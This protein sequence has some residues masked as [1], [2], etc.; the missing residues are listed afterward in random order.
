MSHLIF[1][2]T[3]CDFCYRAILHLLKLDTKKNLLFA[4]LEGTTAKEILVGPNAHY[5]HANS[6]VL[7]ENYDSDDR[8]FYLRSKAI[9]R[10]YWLLGNRLIGWLSF[11]PG[12]LCDWFYR[13][14]AKH[15]HRLHFG[16]V[17][18]EFQGEQF[19]P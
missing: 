2:D 3:D 13:G 12:V 14:I 9:F 1:Y 15:R 18:K 6:L 4:P 8:E 16:W 17:R 10:I 11:L 7:L 5:A 19:L